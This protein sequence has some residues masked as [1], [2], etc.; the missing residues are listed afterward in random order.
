M[1]YNPNMMLLYCNVC[2]H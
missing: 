1:V 2:Y